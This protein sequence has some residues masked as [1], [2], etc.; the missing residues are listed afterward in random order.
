MSGPPK[1]VQDLLSDHKKNKDDAYM[2]QFCDHRNALR[3]VDLNTDRKRQGSSIII[4]TLHNS[5]DANTF[6]A[7][8]NYEQNDFRKTAEHYIVC[9]PKQL[10]VSCQD[11]M[12]PLL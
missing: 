8:I 1:F 10:Q 12:I 6:F 5:V 3:V 7:N 9:P 2:L 4:L 11:L